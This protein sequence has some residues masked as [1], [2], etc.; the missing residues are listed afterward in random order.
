GINPWRIPGAALANFRSG[1]RGQGSSTLT[2]QLSRILFLTPKKT[3][4]RKIKEVILP[5][6]NEKSFTKEE[7][8]TLYCNQVYFGHG[9]YGVEAS[10]QFFF[11]KSI[12]E[13]T[14][15]EAALISG[16]PQTPSRLSPIEHADRALQRRNH[17]LERMAEEKYISM[18]DSARAQAEP[19]RP[20]LRHH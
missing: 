4:E 14:L 17:V 10:S 9:N 8:F 18:E 11:D 1:R 3:Y 5:F 16:L 6:Q 20:H 15:A 13:L 7:I 12:K 2:M 19:L